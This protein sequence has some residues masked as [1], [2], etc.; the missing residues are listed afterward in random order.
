M[1]ACTYLHTYLDIRT[2]KTATLRAWLL[3]EASAVR[4]DAE[5]CV[6]P[7]SIAQRTI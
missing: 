2:H 5:A 1:G 7:C 3:L 4:Y 6:R